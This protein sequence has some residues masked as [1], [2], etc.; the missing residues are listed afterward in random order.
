MCRSSSGLPAHF[1]PRSPHGERLIGL[2]LTGFLLISTH[3]PRTGSDLP[4][5]D[6]PITA[7]ISTHA[8]RTGSDDERRK[9][10]AGL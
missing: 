2:G 6:E 5:Q 3:A 1:N 4:V 10:N 9:K 8:P 7:T